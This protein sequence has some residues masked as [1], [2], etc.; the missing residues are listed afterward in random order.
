MFEYID[1]I[2]IITSNQMRAVVTVVATADNQVFYY[3]HWE[4]GYE[5]DIFNPTQ[6][7]TEIYGD[8]DTGNIHQLKRPH[9]RFECTLSSLFNGGNIGDSFLQN[10]RRLV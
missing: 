4:D 2:P 5:A 7:S 1:T 10:A 3:D 8:G 6:S 9:S